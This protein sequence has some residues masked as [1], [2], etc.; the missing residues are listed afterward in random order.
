M[1]RV[2]VLTVFLAVV[3]ISAFAFG[4]VLGQNIRGPDYAT[5]GATRVPALECQEDELITW[6]QAKLA[7]APISTW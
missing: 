4:L 5:I 2:L 1:S 6:V 7:C 3:V